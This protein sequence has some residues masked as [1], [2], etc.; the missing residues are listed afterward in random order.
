MERA[1]WLHRPWLRRV[2]T[3]LVLLAT[4]ALAAPTH[5][6]AVDPRGSVAIGGTLWWDD[7]GNG[8][9]D[10]RDRALLGAEVEY[11]WGRVTARLSVGADGH[12]SLNLPAA[13][14][15][16]V[17]VAS[18]G[19]TAPQDMGIVPVVKEVGGDEARDSDVDLDNCVR[20]TSPRSGAR[21]TYDA[22]FRTV[23]P[24]SVGDR[25]WLDADAD[26]IQ[27]LGEA[28]L[29]GVTLTLKD[30]DGAVLGTTNTGADGTYQLREYPDDEEVSPGVIE[31]ERD[32]EYKLCFDASTTTGVLPTGVTV[33]ELRATARDI[34][35]DELDSDVGIDGC[36]DVQTDGEVADRTV[37]V[38][39]T[40]A[41]AV[42]ASVQGLA[43][44]DLDMD[45]SQGPRELPLA[46]VRLTLSDPAGAIVRS[47]TTGQ[48]GTYVLSGL[49]AGVESE[50]CFDPSTMTNLSSPILAGLR[51]TAANV[52]DDDTKDSDLTGR[53]MLIT[54][55]R[56]GSALTIDVGFGFSTTATPVAGEAVGDFVW[57]DADRDGVQDPGESPLAGV[58]VTLKGSAGASLGGATTD[59]DGRY[60]LK[61]VLP[62][63]DFDLC[64]DSATATNLPD[65]VTAEDLRP[66]AADASGDEA[67]D[68]DIDPNGC[69]EL[70]HPAGG[71]ALTIDAGFRTPG[72]ALTLRVAGE[73][74]DADHNGLVEVGDEVNYRYDLANVGTVPLTEI[75]V[76]DERIASLACPESVLAPGRTMTCTGGPYQVTAADVTNG[77]I[78]NTP[79]AHGADP[80]GE[81]VVSN[82]DMA[83]LALYRA[84]TNH[85]IS[86]TT[87]PASSGARLV[88]I[89]FYGDD[90]SPDIGLGMASA[91]GGGIVLLAGLASL[92]RLRARRWPADR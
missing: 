46:E 59:S 81:L 13:V 60:H 87:M 30:E 57:L 5:A 26:G 16:S 84:V 73:P 86:P 47:A 41:E 52:A 78:V 6:Q 8:I 9:R 18:F 32:R 2:G 92:V 3:T 17:C 88:T 34:G 76:I 77:R 58:R 49:P 7:N 40:G 10:R 37:D 25:V 36:V 24:A 56:A 89:V 67:L 53:C 44:F 51:P 80:A 68:S 90:S 11:S 74:V 12:Y 15:F 14:P 91:V 45:G 33:A 63:G 22:G 31:I 55:P 75:E 39:F 85:L 70:A 64:F 27:E 69:V 48:N 61:P 43:W 20:G 28:S 1:P 71:A 4:C 83:T 42:V 54:T 19:R 66:T 62:D 72:P 23:G 65:G 50:I 82:E 35:D 38:G 29:P 79:V 21:R